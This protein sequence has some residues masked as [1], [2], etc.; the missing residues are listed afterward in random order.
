MMQRLQREDCE[1][2]CVERAEV[3]LRNQS[4]VE[5]WME[6]HRPQVVVVA[7]AKVGGILANSS[8]PVDFLYDNL[9]IQQ[10][11]VHTAHRLD[12]EK[13]LL[14]GSSCIYPKLAPQP[15]SEDALLTGP[16]EPTNQWYALAKIAGVQLCAAYR[17]QYGRDFI[18]A[19]PTNLYGFNDNFEL[20]SSHV[21]PA[22][23]HKMHVAKTS[24]HDEVEIWGTG[25]PLR[26]FL[27]VKDLVDALVFLLKAYSAP[28]PI[29]V[30][31]GQEV[32][33]RELASLIAKV[34]G[35]EGHFVFDASKPDGP[36]RKLVDTRRLAALG[37]VAK[38][39]L[40]AGISEVYDWF[41]RHHV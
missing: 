11:I 20:L 2:L 26:E 31:S 5:M 22:L 35:Y 33:I 28:E 40:E 7:A 25:T 23:I 19:M 13:L 6:A 29:N 21:L 38:I 1:L 14:L 36:P 32:S 27:H 30:G 15:I 10:N 17:Q 3:D 41:R 24:G 39:E 16:L 8:Y 37:W 18:S 12:C 34:V 9:M 4:A